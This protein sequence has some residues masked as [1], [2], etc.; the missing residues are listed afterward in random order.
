MTF[1]ATHDLCSETD[2]LRSL[3]AWSSG[4]LQGTKRIAAGSC[5]SQITV[6]TV[7]GTLHGYSK[8]SKQQTHGSRAPLAVAAAASDS[9]V[10]ASTSIGVDGGAGGQA[11]S[12]CSD[13]RRRTIE[14]SS[15]RNGRRILQSQSPNT[16]F[17][18]PSS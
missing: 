17:Q 9:S 18:N 10:D 7:P 15:D 11:P 3:C 8:L 4:D 1:F 5:T 12:P 14:H 13:L 6:W 16:N 2:E